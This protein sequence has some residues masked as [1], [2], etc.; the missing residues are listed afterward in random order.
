MVI[1]TFR[2]LPQEDQDEFTG[3][4]TLE[5]PTFTLWRDRFADFAYINIILPPSFCTSSGGIFGFL[6]DTRCTNSFFYGVFAFH[7]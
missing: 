4:G 3:D 2:T 7:Q 6:E 1:S 5:Y